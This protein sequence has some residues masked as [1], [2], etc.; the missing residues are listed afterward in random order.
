MHNPQGNDGHRT[1][2]HK[3]RETGSY[4]EK[5][6]VTLSYLIQPLGF[7][8]VLGGKLHVAFVAP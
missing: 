7:I 5:L 2:T 1:K 8:A 3:G 6:G 4:L